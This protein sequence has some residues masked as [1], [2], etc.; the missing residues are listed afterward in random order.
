MALQRVGR[1]GKQPWVIQT[2]G[3]DRE[4]FSYS[5]GRYQI[6]KSYIRLRRQRMIAKL[7]VFVN[8][9]GLTDNFPN[10][11][12]NIGEAIRSKRTLS[13]LNALPL[14]CLAC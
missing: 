7:R 13:A 12:F 5:V 3:R 14:D 2:V 4:L 8:K 11:T 6:R 10:L 1:I 9:M